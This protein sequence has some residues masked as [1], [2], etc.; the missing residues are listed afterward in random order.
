MRNA[1][2]T[3]LIAVCAFVGGCAVVEKPVTA[4]EDFVAQ[5]GTTVPKGGQ[6]YLNAKGES[7]ALPVDP[8]TGEPN[9]PMVEYDVAK[10]AAAQKAAEGLGSKIPV[11]GALVSAIAGIGG[12]LT[13]AAMR[14]KNAKGRADKGVPQ[15]PAKA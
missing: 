11:W 15:E 2:L 8:V 9:K 14:K 7:T 1:I 4:P 12:G 5:D 10:V 13:I 3:L 6:V